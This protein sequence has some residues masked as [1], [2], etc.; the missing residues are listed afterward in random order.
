MVPVTFISI[1]C[2][3]NYR[4]HPKIIQKDN[5]LITGAQ[6]NPL[7]A[8]GQ[9]LFPPGSSGGGS[10]MN[11]LQQLAQLAPSLMQ[12]MSGGQASQGAVQQQLQMD[13]QQYASQQK[14]HKT[15]GINLWT[16]SK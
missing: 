5:P 14:A 12:Q 13:Y 9:V 3:I 10:G 11:Q 7:Q 6:A 15:S 8:L 4:S 16:F 2:H 1:S